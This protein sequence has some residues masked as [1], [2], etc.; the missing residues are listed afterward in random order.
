MRA[1][2]KLLGI[3]QALRDPESGCPW[4]REQSM[5]SIK[6]YTLEE[7]YEVIDAIERNDMGDL[8]A[9]LGDL[10]FHIVFYAE[11][12]DEMGAFNFSDVVDT[13]NEKLIRRH[14]HVF[15]D[16]TL[17]TSEE[18]KRQ[19]EI[20]KQQERQ[21]AQSGSQ[22]YLDD[23]SAFMPAMLRALKLQK[24]AAAVGFDWSTAPPI[25][26]KIE[27]EIE[28]LKDSLQQPDVNEVEVELGDL[29]FCCINLA[30]HLA[31]DPEMALRRTNT[32]FIERFHH[33]E[34]ALKRQGISF[35]DAT[36]EQM[37]ALWDEAKNIT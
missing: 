29:L 14:P 19:W 18:V 26:A 9:E 30:R 4:D 32:K 11:M 13:V 35:N 10:L 28:E 5:T 12:A 7:S 31:V 15:S 24:R 37:D 8:R 3:M 17:N 16:K 21:A 25:F 1:L 23:I 36:L 33:V 20:T 22:L 34:Q 6:P 2:E 27:E